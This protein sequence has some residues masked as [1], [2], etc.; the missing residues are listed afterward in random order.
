MTLLKLL[1][2]LT[3]IS[4]FMLTSCSDDSNNTDDSKTYI[5]SGHPDWAPIM[6]QDR[7]NIIGAGPEIVSAIMQEL[8]EKVEVKYHGLWDEVQAKA[9]TGEVDI[10]VAAYK[11][12]ERETYMDYSIAYTIDPVSV[13]VKSGNTFAFEKWEDLIGKKGVVTKGDSYGQEFDDFLA[14]NLD[15]IVADTP[16]EAF[17]LILNNQ[18]DYFIYVLYSGENLIE[19]NNMQI[20]VEILPKYVSSENF[21]ITIS[22]KSDLANKMSEINEILQEM[23]SQGKIDQ[24]IQ[25]IKIKSIKDKSLSAPDFWKCEIGNWN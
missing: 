11:T 20:T 1:S 19:K 2:F 5:A 13:F 18:A 22:K 17:Q 8:G 10:L 3:I 23:I 6:Y 21:H 12:A 7:E 25:N 4:F 9:K 14:A 24:I 15:V 16:D